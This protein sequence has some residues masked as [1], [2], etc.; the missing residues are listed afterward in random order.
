[1]EVLTMDHETEIKM[2][3]EILSG[4]KAGMSKK[5]YKY[6]GDGFIVRTAML[7]EKNI[8]PEDETK[9]LVAFAFRNGP[10]EDIH[11]DK[12]SIPANTGHITNDEMKE[13]M[14]C[15]V[16][17]VNM[18]L[19]MRDEKPIMYVEFMEWLTFWQDGVKNWDKPKD[20]IQVA[21]EVTGQDKK[22]ET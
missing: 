22:Q 5:D 1:M 8:T 18:L 21:K 17:R 6:L 7:G 15:A 3:K 12:S 4:M 20:P 11:A 10:L 16:D 2:Y 9:L 19:W 14:K 13:L